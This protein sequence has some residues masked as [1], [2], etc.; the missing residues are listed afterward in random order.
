MQPTSSEP[1]L[2]Q[3]AAGSR[4]T[5]NDAPTASCGGGRLWALVLGAAIVAGLA[6]WLGGEASLNRIK[7]RAHAA[8][9]RGIMLN[10]TGRREVAAADAKNASVAFALLGASLGAALGVAGGL[11][12]RSGRAAAKAALLG[13]IAG[14]TASALMSLALLPAY[15]AY[16]ARNPD[17]A[18]RDL[19]LPMLVHAGIWSAAGAAGGWAFAVGSGARARLAR[20]A[21]GGLA[22]AAL[23]ATA[24]ELIGAAA[25]PSAQTTQFISAT[26]ETRL[27][28]RIAVTVLAAAGVAMAA[29]D[30]RTRPPSPPS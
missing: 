27:L 24:Y 17:E 28:A 25:F 14:A 12:R 5:T 2:P 6:A 23:G 7:P 10:L 16:K 4:G 18:S 26:W 13:L 19:I 11:V 8:N 30:V 29:T 9:S 22:G 21:L 3:S 20:I 1:P 15:N